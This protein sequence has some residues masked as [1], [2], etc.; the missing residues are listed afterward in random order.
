MPFTASY[1]T[2]QDV[3]AAP[4][5]A[6]SGRVL[7]TLSQRLQ[8]P[9][10]AECAHNFLM[11]VRNEY[12]QH[13]DA[14]LAFSE[15]W[16]WLLANGFLCQSPTQGDG[17]MTLTRRGREATRETDFS[18]WVQDQVL[19]AELLHPTLRATALDLYRQ[20]LFDT[21]VFEAFK[22][23]E[24]AIREAAG[25]GHDLVGIRLASRAFHPETGELTDT[26]AEAG[27]KQALLS[28][29][30]GALGSYKNPQSHR[31][32]G[33]DA[34]EAREMLIMASHLIRI[35]ESRRPA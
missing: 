28:L 32:V 7:Q 20:A 16:G 9:G 13:L 21:A 23:L 19:P 17:W 15:A 22:A 2:A 6:L 31:H 34:A 1:R 25:L 14:L 29:M 3:L 33:V 26:R 35:V 27:E 12:G 4:L 18:K 11:S 10:D 24:V 30:T 5:V 8:R